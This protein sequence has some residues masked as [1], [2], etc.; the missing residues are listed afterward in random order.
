MRMMT[1]KCSMY[2]IQVKRRVE[3]VCVD[4]RKSLSARQRCGGAVVD[5]IKNQLEHQAD[6]AV[7]SRDTLNMVDDVI[8]PKGSSSTRWLTLSTCYSPNKTPWTRP[9]EML[10]LDR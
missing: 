5:V 9:T 6:S 10:Y 2:A 8:D 1:V 3:S 4:W 7:Y